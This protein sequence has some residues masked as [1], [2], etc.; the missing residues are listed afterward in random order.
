[1]DK[2]SVLNCW[3]LVGNEMF[4]LAR[5]I[6][7]IRRQPLTFIAGCYLATW[8]PTAHHVSLKPGSAWSG[9]T[10]FRHWNYCVFF[11]V[12]IGKTQ[13][14]IQFEV[15]RCVVFIYLNHL[16]FINSA[17]PC[18]KYY[19]LHYTDRLL[20]YIYTIYTIIHVIII[21]DLRIGI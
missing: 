16:L 13:I 6:I 5:D 15:E 4:V 9:S 8:D 17:K 1:M 3:L 12:K 19:E 14:N 18:V 10:C 7:S 2:L 20:L 21:N 11:Y